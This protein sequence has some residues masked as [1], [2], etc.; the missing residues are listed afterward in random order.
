MP[1]VLPLLREVYVAETRELA[2]ERAR[3]FLAAKYESYLTWGQDK[4]LPAGDPLAMP[5]DQLTESRFIVGTPDDLIRGLELYT[6][7]LGVNF[8]TLRLQWPGMP[9]AHV[10]DA[11]RLIGEQVIPHFKA[12]SSS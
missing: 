5:F 7:R 3:P 4:A 1:T 11:I 9:H 8:V 6:E 12:R 2:H 10:V